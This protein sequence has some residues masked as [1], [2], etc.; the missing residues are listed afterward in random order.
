MGQIGPKNLTNCPKSSDFFLY[1]TNKR[2]FICYQSFRFLQMI[3]IE[4]YGASDFVSR[5]P[6]GSP[7]TKVA[8]T[9]NFCSVWVPSS[10]YIVHQLLYFLKMIFNEDFGSQECVQWSPSC[11]SPPKLSQYMLKFVC[12]DELKLVNTPQ[13]FDIFSAHEALDRCLTLLTPF[14]SLNQLS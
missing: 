13:Q 5:S 12:S 9:C 4:S 11:L 14:S 3:C 6:N 7:V 10:C 8:K 2:L 1:G